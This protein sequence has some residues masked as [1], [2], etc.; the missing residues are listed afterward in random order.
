MSGPHSFEGVEDEFLNWKLL[1]YSGRIHAMLEGAKGTPRQGILVHRLNKVI[2]ELVETFKLDEATLSKHL[3]KIKKAREAYD[4]V[5]ERIS[6]EEHDK[7]WQEEQ[8]A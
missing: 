2:E 8:E 7:I 5:A 6:T 4:A 3:P 1:S